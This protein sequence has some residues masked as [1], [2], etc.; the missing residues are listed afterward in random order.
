MRGLFQAIRHLEASTQPSREFRLEPRAVP[1]QY[2]LAC[3]CRLL[4]D[5]G[6]RWLY[7][8][9][10]TDCLFGGHL[11]AMVRVDALRAWCRAGL[12]E[13]VFFE[14][15]MAEHLAGTERIVREMVVEYPRMGIQACPVL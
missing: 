3:A 10:E 7:G 5:P 13:A 2:A 9:Q 14:T 11:P 6:L 12:D 1:H 8:G 4:P 15:A